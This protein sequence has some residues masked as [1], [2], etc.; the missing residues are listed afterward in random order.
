MIGIR[1]LLVRNL[2]I[3]AV[4]EAVAMACGIASSILL[5]RYLGV[6]G[7]GTFNYAFAFMYFF[8]T[9]NDLGINTI[10]VREI[11]REPERAPEIIGS[12]RTLRMVIASIVLAAAWIAIWLWP[13]DPALRRPLAVFALI[14]P[15]SAL[16]IPSLIFQT[17]MRFE[18][19][20][21]VNIVNRVLG[22]ALMIGMMRAGLGVTAMLAA[23]LLAEA[24]AQVLNWLLARGL[25]RLE[26]RVDPKAWGRVLKASLALLAS[27]LLAAVINRIDF[28]MLERMTSLESVGLYG[29]AYRITSM[30]EK[31]PMFV[32]ATLYPIMS[33]LAVDD[34]P[35]LRH[36]Y[37]RAIWR[38]GAIGL[39]LGVLAVLGAPWF[40]T[41]VFGEDYRASA[42]VL[43]YLVWATA[44][45]YPAM[46]GG[47]L[48]IA[49]HRTHDSALALAA[50]AVVNIILNVM[51]IPSRGVE[52]AAMATAAAYVVILGLT[53]IAVER[54]FAR[55]ARQARQARETQA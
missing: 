27:M 10:A 26:W 2:T 42:A 7:F 23:L 47:S 16:N 24:V 35:R 45:L 3:Q 39:A 21:I 32:M 31:F 6:E 11:A 15:I 53:L 48:L 12:L 30:L 55:E 22:L 49:L 37:R 13:M 38:L 44:C 36:V 50:G 34:L 33:R 5:S 43:Q 14:V 8:L 46:A 9:L 1:A 54:Q 25:V 19:A 52:G 29:A 17:S 4:S 51:L 28:I 18:R 40:M 41:T 20:G